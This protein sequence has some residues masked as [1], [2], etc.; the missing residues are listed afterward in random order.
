MNS[1][2]LLSDLMVEFFKKISIYQ[3]PP[4]SIE[5][6][7]TSSKNFDTNSSNDFGNQD[8]RELIVTTTGLQK[9]FGDDADL[10]QLFVNGHVVDDTKTYLDYFEGDPD[11]SRTYLGQRGADLSDDWYLYRK[12]EEPDRNIPPRLRKLFETPDPIFDQNI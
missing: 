2:V 4:S 9:E 6:E 1:R 3:S 7:R 10:A 5:Q 11:R 12:D 8:Q